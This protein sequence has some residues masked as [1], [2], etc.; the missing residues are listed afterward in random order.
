MKVEGDRYIVSLRS[1]CNRPIPSDELGWRTFAMHLSSP[2][3]GSAL[4]SGTLCSQ[5]TR[6]NF[7][8]NRR[9]HFEDLE[10]PERLVFVGDCVYVQNPTYGGG[11]TLCALEAVELRKLLSLGVSSSKAIQRRISSMIDTRW[12]MSASNDLIFP[13]IVGERSLGAKLLIM[14]LGQLLSLCRYR[15]VANR[16]LYIMTMLNT[17]PFAVF[18]PIFLVAVFLRIAGV[19]G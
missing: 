10:L 7:P 8:E 6:F 16:Y 17:N 13:E 5:I 9:V 4:K 12:R 2:V 19:L 15:V 14:Y 1:F 18:H 11:M 3:L